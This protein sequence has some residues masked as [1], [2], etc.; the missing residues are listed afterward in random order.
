MNYYKA[1]I[2]EFMFIL[3]AFGF[4]E[5]SKLEAYESFD[6][7]TVRALLEST[8]TIFEER[9][10]PLNKSGDEEG[11]SWDAETHDVKTPKGFREA[12]QLLVEEGLIGMTGPAEYEGGGAPESVRCFIS[13]LMASTNKSFSMAPGLTRDLVSALM[14]HGSDEQKKFYLPKLVTGVWTG[15]MC[16]TEPQCGT[17]LG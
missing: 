10:M 12:Y 14:E 2:D 1:P 7:D 9:L 13:E 16:L 11:V 4:D 3:D 5:V 15:T 6:R 8:A 17:D